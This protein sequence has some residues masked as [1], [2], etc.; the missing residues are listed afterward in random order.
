MGSQRK[1]EASDCKQYLV[2]AE[3]EW[4]PD[5]FTPMHFEE[6]KEENFTAR[7]NQSN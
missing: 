1:G 5:K 7:F 2:E 3:V 6:N 4:G